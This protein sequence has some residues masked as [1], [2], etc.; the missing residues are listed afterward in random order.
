[1]PDDVKGNKRSLGPKPHYHPF[2]SPSEQE[3]LLLPLQLGWASSGGWHNLSG[4]VCGSAGWGCCQWDLVPR[5]LKQ[6]SEWTQVE[7]LLQG[8]AHTGPG[9]YQPLGLTFK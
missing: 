2:P 5:L 7:H 6:F 4:S 3:A 8:L 1:M 9:Q